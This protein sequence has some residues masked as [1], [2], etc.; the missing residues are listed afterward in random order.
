MVEKKPKSIK[1]KSKKL[2]VKEQMKAA[3]AEPLSRIPKEDL[4]IT[5]EQIEAL[6]AKGIDVLKT[7]EDAAKME[8]FDKESHLPPPSS[9]HLDMPV[10]KMPEEPESKWA[11]PQPQLSE[12]QVGKIYMLKGGHILRYHGLYSGRGPCLA[13]QAPGV[14]LPVT[15][16]EAVGYSAD[17]SE[18][19][20]KMMGKEMIAPL[21]RNVEEL[22][23]RALVESAREIELVIEELEKED[24]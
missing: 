24:G 6:G 8:V 21:K 14:A 9:G 3:T 12:M 23:A 22:K 4:V 16:E 19:L 5:K 2:T 11:Q 20:Y 18:V 17:I 1:P 15:P 10:K 13:F 7:V